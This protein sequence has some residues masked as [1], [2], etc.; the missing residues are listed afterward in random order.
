MWASESS[1]HMISPST[2]RAYHGVVRV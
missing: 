2:Y 1:V